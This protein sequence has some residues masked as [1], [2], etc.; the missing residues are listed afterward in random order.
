M[1]TRNELEILLASDSLE[2]HR[3]LETWAAGEFHLDADNID[4]ITDKMLDAAPLP[5]TKVVLIQTAPD[6]SCPYYRLRATQI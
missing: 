3:E 2:F 4:E 6:D 1:K 5:I